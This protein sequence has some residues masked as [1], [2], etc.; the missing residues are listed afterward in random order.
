M[1]QLAAPSESSEGP[2]SESDRAGQVINGRYR[3]DRLI[4][5]SGSGMI[6]LS[7]EL[8][9]QHRSSVKLIATRLKE[10]DSELAQ[11]FREEAQQCARL[12]HPSIAAIYDYGETEHGDLFIAMENVDGRPLAEVIAVEGPLPM[13]RILNIAVRICRALK[14]A[15]DHNVLHRDL[16]PSKILLC[17][18]HLDEDLVKLLDVGVAGLLIGERARWGIADSQDSPLGSPKYLS[19]EQIR[20]EALDPR[21]DM[22][23][24]GAVLFCMITG[25]PPFVGARAVEIAE[26]HLRARP[27]AMES[28]GYKRAVPHP[29]FAIV[30]RCLE[31]QRENRFVSMAQLITELK[32][33]YQASV[34]RSISSEEDEVSD[35]LGEAHHDLAEALRMSRRLPPDR[36]PDPKPA[37]VPLP[38]QR[39]LEAPL[40]T[41][42]PTPVPAPPIPST[43]PLPPL[44]SSVTPVLSAI[45]SITPVMPGV[46]SLTPAP[47]AQVSPIL[48][49]PPSPS[50]LPWAIAA[51]SLLIAILAVLSVLF[52]PGTNRPSPSPDPPAADFEE[53]KLTFES[54]PRGARVEEAGVIL[55]VTPFIRT[56]PR[57][58]ENRRFNFLL[59]GYRP[60]SADASMGVA[61]STLRV[62]LEKSP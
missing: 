38:P 54:V 22:Y 58:Q 13:E 39:D 12:I 42:I 9:T 27:P 55:G 1:R 14:H 33:A 6:Y 62:V 59:D 43:T 10:F 28:V 41:P 2:G 46:R 45:P 44:V 19:P 32:I 48:R 36:V 7:T 4:A 57:A 53:V 51:F 21:S 50:R 18:R 24:F 20:G 56:Y 5:A 25:V 8:A 37:R 16:K 26:Q 34:G 40:F 15:H 35:D 47:A 61:K 11:R 60:G 17:G 29:V 49:P 30:S 52:G 23:S 3:L 31:K